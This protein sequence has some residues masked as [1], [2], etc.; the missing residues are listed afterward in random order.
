MKEF[1]TFI[2]KLGIVSGIVSLI[3]IIIFRKYIFRKYRFDLFV[4]KPGSGKTTLMVK[5]AIKALQDGNIVYCN[6]DIDVPNVRIFNASDIGLGRYFEN[7]SLILIDEPNLYWDNRQY[8]SMRKETVEWFRLYRHNQVNIRMFT[9]TFDIDKKLRNLC[10]D[11]HI[12]NKIIGTI[13]VVRRLQKNISIKES[14]LDAESQ[15][16]DELNFIP[17]FIPGAL[18]IC[19]IPK[20]TPYFDSFSMPDGIPIEYVNVKVDSSNKSMIRKLRLR[21]KKKNVTDDVTT[22][23]SIISLLAA[24]NERNE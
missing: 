5:M 13:A 12:V 14:A 9:Q 8:K 6:V 3:Y 15:I 22:S 1:I 10:S 17:I 19:F 11:I 18:Q 20:W 23:E 24:E 16:V 21:K 4:G 7:G 2:L